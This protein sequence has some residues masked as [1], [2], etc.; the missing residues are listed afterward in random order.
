MGASI[1]RGIVMTHRLIPAIAIVFWGCLALDAIADD[2]QPLQPAP[3]QFP[4]PKQIA[5][6]VPFWVLP[7]RP[8]RLDTREGW[9]MYGVNSAGRFRP[10]VVLSPYGSYY[11]Y[12]GE[13]YP[14]WPQ[15]SVVM[16]R[17]SN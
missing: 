6:A 11:L 2:V 13:P 16:P 3:E 5:P 9:S 15:P 10:R 1:V 14:W 4:A 8:P 17:T 12:T 7:P